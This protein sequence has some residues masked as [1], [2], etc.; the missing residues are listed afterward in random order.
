MQIESTSPILH[1]ACTQFVPCCSLADR[2]ESDV[3]IAI[4]I[5]A[6]RPNIFTTTL[7]LVLHTWAKVATCI[8]DMDLVLHLS[9]IK[10]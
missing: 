7:V 3:Q 2:A 8:D 10:Y 6:A 1:A 5:R 4:Y 9:M